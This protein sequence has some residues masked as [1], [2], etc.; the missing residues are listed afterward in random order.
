MKPED[1]MKLLLSPD[2]ILVEGE[3]NSER[4][5]RELRD[6]DMA[7]RLNVIQQLSLSPI[8]PKQPQLQQQLTTLVN[9]VFFPTSEPIINSAHKKSSKPS[10]K[11]KYANKRNIITLKDDRQTV[12]APEPTESQRWEAKY[13]AMLHYK[14]QCLWRKAVTYVVYLNSVKTR[15]CASRLFSRVRDDI[16]VLFTGSKVFYRRNE[17]ATVSVG[18]YLHLGLSVVEC[19]PHLTDICVTTYNHAAVTDHLLT[20]QKLDHSQCTYTKTTHHLAL[21]RIYFSYDVLLKCVM[22]T[23]N[24]DAG[25]LPFTSEKGA[26]RAAQ[27]SKSLNL[28]IDGAMS[29]Y[30]MSHLKAVKSA[31]KHSKAVNESVKQMH[32]KQKHIH[33]RNISK[34]YVDTISDDQCVEVPSSEFKHTLRVLTEHHKTTTTIAEAKRDSNTPTS[35][36]SPSTTPEEVQI[37]ARDYAVTFDDPLLTRYNL[38]S[39]VLNEGVRCAGLVP[40]MI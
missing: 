15:S 36:V 1:V 27:R 22:G 7:V 2:N 10:P 37:C 33:H 18:I 35:P 16:R 40:V 38:T 21:P 29:Q 11:Y 6:F 28:C 19:V 13:R 23:H 3:T 8:L 25:L 14:Y 30:I 5:D 4:Q 9:E 20:T 24:F 12:L 17:T 34:H 26:K 39:P 32:V 31:T